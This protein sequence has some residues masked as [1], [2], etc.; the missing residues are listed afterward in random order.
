VV[1]AATRLQAGSIYRGHKVSYHLGTY[2]DAKVGGQLPNGSRL[3]CGLW[4]PQTR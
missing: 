3:S 4:R 1:T 2:A